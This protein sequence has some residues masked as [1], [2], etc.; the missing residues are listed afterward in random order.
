MGGAFGQGVDRVE[1]EVT[2]EAQLPEAKGKKERSGQRRKA[3]ELALQALFEIDF[4]GHDFEQALE[5]LAE[6]F[7][8]PKESEAFVRELVSG[9]VDDK[10]SLDDTI[11]AFAPAW[12]LEEL[13]SVDRNILRLGIYEICLKKVP[14][15]V[16]I[17]EAVELAKSFGSES[18]AKFVNGVLGSVYTHTTKG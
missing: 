11:R 5:W 4:V 9:V 15:K 17:N 3:R 10:E 14:A 16:A 2:V 8:M 12:P 1:E 7:D 13:A 6:E 18:S